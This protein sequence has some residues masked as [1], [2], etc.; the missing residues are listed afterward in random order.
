MLKVINKHTRT[1]RQLPSRHMQLV[2]M[3]SMAAVLENVMESWTRWTLLAEPL[4]KLLV[5]LVVILL[6]MLKCLM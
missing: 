2:C 1:N 3:E 4:Q 6:E 5:A